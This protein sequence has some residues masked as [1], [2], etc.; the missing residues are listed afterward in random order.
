MLTGDHAFSSN[1]GR[2]HHL[3]REHQLHHQV[4]HQ[5]VVCSGLARVQPMRAPRRGRRA[6]SPLPRGRR[7]PPPRR[8]HGRVRLPPLRDH[9]SA[10]R[11]LRAAGTSA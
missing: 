2:P 8:V 6:P 3:H 4:H 1:R 9:R 11:A 7:D 5:I 10:P